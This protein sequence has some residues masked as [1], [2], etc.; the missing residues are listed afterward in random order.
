[1]TG[2]DSARSI[3]VV[4]LLWRRSWVIL[5][6][7]ILAGAAAYYPSYTS[8][9]LYRADA[10]LLY[11][12]GREY[13]PVGPS[14]VHRMYGETIQVS[15]DNAL[16]T[17]MRL[18]VSREVLAV[19]VATLAAKPEAP[20]PL[21]DVNALAE[22]L[23]VR[24]VEGAT[25]VTIGVEQP[26]GAVA[27]ALVDAVIDAYLAR[28]AELFG[29]SGAG[30][31]FEQQIAGFEAVLASVLAEMTA[32]R[33]SSGVSDPV[34][35]QTVLS[36]RLLWWE[37]LSR[38]AVPDPAAEGE[39]AAT[40]QALLDLARVDAELKNLE[41]RRAAAAA[42]LQQAMAERDGWALDQRYADGVSPVVEVVEAPAAG[43][44]PVGISPFFRTVAAAVLGLFI[45]AG[46]VVIGAFLSANRRAQARL[47]S[48]DERPAPPTQDP[49]ST[50][51]RVT[52]VNRNRG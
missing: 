30:A 3:D 43:A 14:E 37:R 48:V 39:I 2:T 25:M 47:A 35:E 33:E 6:V 29:Q 7:G 31:V 36:D 19:A 1:M 32:L 41:A 40:R 8:T 23:S 16:F 26:D 18:M 4:G 21:P 49:T 24:R 5:L 45:G 44:D 46:L 51:S 34:V 13:F 15:L 20:S 9:P 10:T 17:E 38:A 27:A 11:R 50:G 22:A 12:F 52:V 42:G 28:R